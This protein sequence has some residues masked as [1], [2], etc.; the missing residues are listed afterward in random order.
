MASGGKIL[1]ESEEPRVQ[2]ATSAGSH[3]VT[4]LVPSKGSRWQLVLL[5]SHMSDAEEKKPTN[6]KPDLLHGGAKKD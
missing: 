1:S 2:L 5:M 6:W 4:V 3:D